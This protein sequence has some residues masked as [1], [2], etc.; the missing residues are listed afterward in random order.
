MDVEHT[1]IS[2]KILFNRAYIKYR[3]QLK[4]HELI[5]VSCIMVQVEI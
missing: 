2:L 3:N 5:Y 4:A 1:D